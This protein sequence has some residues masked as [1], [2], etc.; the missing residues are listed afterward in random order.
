MLQLPPPPPPLPCCH[1]CGARHAAGATAKLPLPLPLPPHRR[2]FAAAAAIAALPPPPPPPLLCWHR[3]R[4]R[5]A[6]ALPASTALSPLPACYHCQRHA[7]VNNAIALVFIVIVIVFI[8]AVY[9][10]VAATAFSWL[11]LFFAPTIAINSQ[12]E[13]SMLFR[14]PIDLKSVRCAAEK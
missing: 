2:R 14:N 5:H 3:N 8:V 11:L 9:I 12:V 13:H 4:C 10:T 6:T 7:A 1:C